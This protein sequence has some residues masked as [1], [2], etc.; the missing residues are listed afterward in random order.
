MEYISSL[1]Q[2]L[3]SG[4]ATVAALSSVSTGK[5][6]LNAGQREQLHNNKKTSTRKDFLLIQVSPI[7]NIRILLNNCPF[8]KQK[9]PAD[10]RAYFTEAYFLDSLT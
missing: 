10:P 4:N 8:R 1:N 3:T 2:R 6:V 5:I 9:P 7:Y